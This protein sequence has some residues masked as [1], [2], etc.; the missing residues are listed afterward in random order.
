MV[1]KAINNDT[2]GGIRELWRITESDNYL[3]NS[4]TI[5]SHGYFKNKVINFSLA[6]SFAAQQKLSPIEALIKV[7]IFRNAL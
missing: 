5:I 2:L 6:D 3:L 4:S 7:C 1:S